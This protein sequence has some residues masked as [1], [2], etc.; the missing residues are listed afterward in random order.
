MAKKKTTKA[1]SLR[2]AGS[3]TMV[4]GVAKGLS[5]YFDL[6]VVL[7]R[8]IFIITSFFYLSGIV[9]YCVLWIILPSEKKE[10]PVFRVIVIIAVLFLLALLLSK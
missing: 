7:I 2:R 4:A 1:K 3:G 6:D 9:A 10:N 5:N 8:A